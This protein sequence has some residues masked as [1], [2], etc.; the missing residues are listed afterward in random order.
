MKT[1]TISKRLLL[2]MFVLLL[3]ALAC[4]KSQE[5]NPITEEP[6]VEE[7]QVVEESEAVVEQPVAAQEGDILFQDDFQDGQSDGWNI[8]AAWYVQQSEDVYTFEASGSGGAWVPTGGNWSNYAYEASAQ[9]DTGSLLL[10]FNLTK[11]GRYLLRL[12][13]AGLYLVKEYPAKN[14]SVLAQTGPVSLGEWHNLNI[15]AYD[16]HIQVYVDQD[17][18][19]DYNDTAPLSKGTIAVTA[20]E[21]SQVAVDDVLVTKTGPLPEGVVQAPPPMENQPELDMGSDDDGS[22]SLD[23]VDLTDDAAGEDQQAGG[24]DLVVLEATFDPD[25]V[26][27]GQPFTANYVIQNQGDVDAGAFTLLWKFHDATGIGVCSWDYDSLGAGETVWGACTKTTNAQPGQSPTTLTVDFEGEIPES[28]EG[29]NELSPTLYVINAAQ[30]D[31]GGANTGQ[32]DL[33]VLEATFDPDPVIS[34]QPFTANYV[35]QNQ[36]DVDAGA[37]TLLWKFHDATGVGVCSWDYDSLGAGETVWGACTKTTNAQPGQSPA[38]LT[39]DVEDEISESNEGNNEQTPTLIVAAAEGGGNGG[40]GADLPDLSIVASRHQMEPNPVP[41]NGI[42][43]TVTY[44]VVNAGDVVAEAS[45]A[46]WVMA[47]SGWSFDCDVP[48]LAPNTSKQCEIVIVGVPSQPGNYGTWVIVDYEG[49]IAESD[50]GNN[51]GEHVVLEVYEP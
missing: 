10:S 44:H 26:I 46:H 15:R 37:F 40:E 16:G 17:L 11:T 31:G 22:L 5:T 47:G 51:E 9:L 8:T 6:I 28:N 24:P 34:G 29:N 38:T 33:V 35:I 27:S 7:E 20:Q 18:W 1:N 3:A 23:E 42:G 49:I 43:F 4:G 25:P 45:T 19:V 41:T 39:V 50:E 14:Y 30:D 21:G 48:S 13:E 36:G 12:D 2:I 32:P